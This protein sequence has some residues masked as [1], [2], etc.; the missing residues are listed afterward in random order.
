MDENILV[1]KAVLIAFAGGVF[2]AL[3]WLWFWLKQDRA[4]PEPKGLI[5]ISFFAGMMSVFLVLPL[6]NFAVTI[7]PWIMNIVDTLGTS[8]SFTSPLDTTI[9]TILWAFIEEFA[10]YFA[11][12]FIAFKSIHFNE[13]LDAVIYLI[14]VALGFAAM[15][16]S[17]YIFKS[18]HESS[19]WGVVLDGN[20]RF[21][22]ATILH[23]ASSALLGIAIA[24]SFYSKRLLTR[25]L[26]A[27]LGLIGATLLHTY[28]NLSIIEVRDTLSALVVFSRFWLVI[29]GIIVLL[30]I[31]KLIQPKQKT[32]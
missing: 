30:S 28:F 14:T 16:N 13:P 22:G 19:V 15:E 20:L 8:L 24:F 21:I 32:L 27:T 25:T 17:L 1:W 6:E 23:I 12:L 18:L 3:L 31:V 5:A 2:P 29:I 26:V 10:K 9:R 4:S 11:V 7:L